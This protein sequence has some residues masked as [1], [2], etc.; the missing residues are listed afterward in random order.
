MKETYSLKEV[1]LY[2]NVPQHVLIHLCEKDVVIPKVDT[3]GRGKFRVFTKKNLF[4]FTIALELRRYEIPV[5]VARVINSVLSSFEKS[6][7]KSISGFKLPDSITGSSPEMELFLYGGDLVVFTL[8]KKIKLGF[9]IKKVIKGEV[10]SVR[11]QKLKSLP[12]NYN[13]FLKINL[14]DIAKNLI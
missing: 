10:K 14:S 4:E 2:L 1:Q 5:S 3:G 12:K 9:D 13:S 7:S 11:V 8:G 6:V